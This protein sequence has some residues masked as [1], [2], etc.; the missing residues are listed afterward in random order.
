MKFRDCLRCA[1]HT[2]GRGTKTRVC[3]SCVDAD[4]FEPGGG[5]DELNPDTDLGFDNPFAD[6]SSFDD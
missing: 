3:G 4:N 1:Y 6:W 5:R 2:A